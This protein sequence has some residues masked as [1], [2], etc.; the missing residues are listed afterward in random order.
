MWALVIT[1]TLVYIAITIPFNTAFLEDIDQTYKRSF[2]FVD[3]IFAL[4]IIVALFSTYVTKA[5]YEEKR[6]KQIL[7]NYG[8]TWMFIDVF[9]SI[10]FDQFIT[11]NKISLLRMFKF[12]K[13]LKS[14]RL[15]KYTKILSQVAH[16]VNISDLTLRLGA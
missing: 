16:Q 15:F 4:D 14:I 12:A 8:R 6:C 5:G 3:V 10:P 1:I 11:S 7:V 9:T 2:Y 13:I